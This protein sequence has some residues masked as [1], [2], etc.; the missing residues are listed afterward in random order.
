MRVLKP[1][2]LILFLAVPA[3][4]GTIQFSPDGSGTFYAVNG[5]DPSPGNVLAVDAVPL[6]T[7]KSFQLLYQASITN[8]INPSGKDFNPPGLG[9]TYQITVLGSFTETVTS[10]TPGLAVFSLASTQSS[11]SFFE[12]F[13][14]PAVISNSLAGT[15]YAAGTLVLSG[16]PDPKSASLGLLPTTG[17]VTSFDQFITNN[18]PGISSI[19]GSGATL[20]GIRVTSINPAFVDS[21]VTEISFN[22]SLVA[23]FQQQNPSALFMNV[24]GNGPPT[25]VPDIGTINGQS[26]PDF[27]LQ[28]DANFS[29]STIPE[30]SGLVLGTIGIMTVLVSWINFLKCKRKSLTARV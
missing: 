7:G 4:A 9:S 22:T 29:F 6:T 17:S 28:A 20:L 19:T 23:P 15:G 11:N 30:P 3:H 27:Q 14:N 21:P 13:S 5:M 10:V 18:Y 25:V 12:L 26:G 8:L 24:H 16:V 2:A 1:L